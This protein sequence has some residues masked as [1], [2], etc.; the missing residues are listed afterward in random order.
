MCEEICSFAP[1]HVFNERLGINQ[2]ARN[3]CHQYM[4]KKRITKGHSRTNAV[5]HLNSLIYQ[6]SY[7]GVAFPKN[8]KWRLEQS[9]QLKGGTRRIGPVEWNWMR[10]RKLCMPLSLINFEKKNIALDKKD[11]NLIKKL[12][13]LRTI[14]MFDMHRLIDIFNRW[15]Y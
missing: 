14:T 5:T 1:F 3:L 11:R 15:N 13:Q 2:I 7:V 9:S 6:V 8:I 4:H 10:S 12:S